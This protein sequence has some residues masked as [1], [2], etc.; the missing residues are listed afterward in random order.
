MKL[1]SVREEVA[2][3]ERNEKPASYLAPAIAIFGCY[4]IHLLQNLLR[5]A[6]GAAETAPLWVFVKFSLESLRVAILFG[7]G[8]IG[9]ILIAKRRDRTKLS[10]IITGISFIGATATFLATLR[11][12][13]F[14]LGL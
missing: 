1:Y 11:T 2:G 3:K 4:L 7:G 9:L 10:H 8:L 12:V 14:I 5:L 6:L 13:G